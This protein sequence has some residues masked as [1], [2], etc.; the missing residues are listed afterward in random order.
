MFGL[1]GLLL[2]VGGG[3]VGW[4]VHEVNPYIDLDR[5]FQTPEVQSLPNRLIVQ[6]ASP[7]GA[8]VAQVLFHPATGRHYLAIVSR[9]QR[10]RVLLDRALEVDASAPAPAVRLTW[11]GNDAVV[12]DIAGATAGQPERY[13][14]DIGT[15][16]FG[17]AAQ[18]AASAPVAEA[19]RSSGPVAAPTAGARRD[20][21]A[22]V[23][24]HG[25]DTVFVYVDGPVPEGEIDGPLLGLP[26]P[27]PD[28]ADALSFAIL[29]MLAGPTPPERAA[30]LLSTW[31]SERTAG[32]LREVTLRDGFA[33]V[34]FEDFRSIIP[35][36][37]GSAGSM[38]LLRHLEATVFQFPEVQRAEFRI[39]GDCDELMAWLQIGCVPSLRSSFR[40]PDGYR[41][42]VRGEDDSASGAGASRP[43]R[44]G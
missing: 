38:M 7:D 30:R 35:N 36:A 11:R 42:A 41:M 16:A 37:V 10:T 2:L 25:Y 6:Q 1:A 8:H 21:L 40:E 43:E 31:F 33:V 32:M 22:T 44:D 20:T 23:T 4:M 9:P 39:N 24:L 3:V 27:V 12:L 17:R 26:R 13:E 34:D 15:F 14:F 5:G 19:D 28:T 18:P 29:Q